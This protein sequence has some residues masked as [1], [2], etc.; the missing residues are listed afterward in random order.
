VAHLLNTQLSLPK[1]R[2]AGRPWLK[3]LK[4]NRVDIFFALPHWGYHSSMGHNLP[5]NFD[6]SQK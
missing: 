4:L 2:P 1:N 5:I 3:E 6:Q